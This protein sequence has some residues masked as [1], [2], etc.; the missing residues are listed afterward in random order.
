MHFYQEIYQDFDFWKER[1]TKVCTLILN[2]RCV[3]ALYDIF[4][5]SW[6]LNYLIIYYESQHLVQ[7]KGVRNSLSSDSQNG[8]YDFYSFWKVL[9]FFNEDRGVTL[10]I[11]LQ[12]LFFAWIILAAIT[13]VWLRPSKVSYASALFFFYY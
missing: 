2:L 12:F 7:S 13:S 4:S 11:S 6:K 5:F 9:D 10:I 1:N 3:L 8:I